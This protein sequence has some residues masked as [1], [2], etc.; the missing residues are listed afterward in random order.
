MEQEVRAEEDN[1][2]LEVNAGGELA[3]FLQTRFG[4]SVGHWILIN[5]NVVW[6]TYV[7]T[8]QALI[9]K[10]GWSYSEVNPW[11]RTH[12]LHTVYE[13][14]IESN[15]GCGLLV[16]RLRQVRNIKHW[17]HWIVVK[18]AKE[19]TRLNFSP[20]ILRWFD[21][22]RK[23]SKSYSRTKKWLRNWFKNK[24]KK[25]WRTKWPSS[26]RVLLLARRR[27]GRIFVR[28]IS[29]S[30]KLFV[31]KTEYGFVQTARFSASTKTTILEWSLKW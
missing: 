20:K 30:L 8:L 4:G 12:I 27:L 15:R 25:C 17:T 24:S 26:K 19:K 9:W 1:E 28:N 13:W 3:C 2:W 5:Y 7:W 31:S 14:T 10:L 23:Q 6:R 16:S 22:L 29:E 21:L 11:V 18:S